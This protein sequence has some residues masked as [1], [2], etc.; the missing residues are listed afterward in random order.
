MAVAEFA[1]LR[2]NL[3]TPD[4]ILLALLSQPDSEPASILR[5]LLSNPSE[6]AE[7][8]KGRIRQ[9]YQR[10]A[11]VQA[12]QIVAT[13]DVA[14]LFR[15]AYEEAKQLGD[16]YISTGTLFDPKTGQTAEV[17]REEGI[18]R[19]QVRKA[20]REIRAGRTI[21]SE[22][23]ETDKALERRFH[24]ILVREPSV[25]ETIR[26]LEGIAPSYERHHR[27]HFAQGAL[28]SAAQLAERYSSDRRLPD[29]AVDLLGAAS[30]HKYLRQIAIPREVKEL[31]RERQRLLR[32][33]TQAFNGQAVT[34]QEPTGV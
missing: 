12:N 9:Q 24:P 13:Q 10:A 22:D 17:L 7:R 2:Q 29:K 27:V 4:F 34:V 14:A 31:E 3:L 20:L 19:D 6:A 16:A 11:P 33:K 15:L 5:N 23:A 26:M 18:N 1:S 30:S 25:E 8:I 28:E 21:N 32:G